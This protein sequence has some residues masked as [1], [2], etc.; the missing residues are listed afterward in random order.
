MTT[1]ALGPSGRPVPTWVRQAIE[2]LCHCAGEELFWEAASKSAGPGVAFSQV[3]ARDGK[4][5]TYG[6]GIFDIAVIDGL[7]ELV[8]A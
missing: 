8:Y 3:S 5:N 7:F 6:I 4:G 2:N 1:S